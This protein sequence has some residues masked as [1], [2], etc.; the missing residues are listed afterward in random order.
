MEQD[1]SQIFAETL[2]QVLNLFA[3]DTS[4]YKSALA[5]PTIKIWKKIDVKNST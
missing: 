5:K 3:E 2:D 1:N 4:T